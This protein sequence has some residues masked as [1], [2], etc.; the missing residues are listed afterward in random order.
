MIPYASTSQSFV[1]C[2]RGRG[3]KRATGERKTEDAEDQE[4]MQDL[5][6]MDDEKAA[7]AIGARLTVQPTCESPCC[8]TLE[9]TLH[10]AQASRARCD[11]ISWRRL[12]GLSVCTIPKST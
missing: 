11:R 5:G 7:G 1:C 4:M 2:R 8:S 6:A 10:V 12:I 9:L 3:P